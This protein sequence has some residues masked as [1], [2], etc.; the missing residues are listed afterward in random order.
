MFH[1]RTVSATLLVLLVSVPSPAFCWGPGAPWAS[2]LETNKQ[3]S[4]IRSGCTCFNPWVGKNQEFAGEKEFLCENNNWCFVSCNSKCSDKT[5]LPGF[6]NWR[7]KSTFACS[8]PDLEAN[9]ASTQAT[10]AYTPVSAVAT[11]VSTPATSEPTSVATSESKPGSPQNQSFRIITSKS[12]ESKPASSIATPESTPVISAESTPTTSES[13]PVSSATTAYTPVSSVAYSESTPAVSASNP[14]TSEATSASSVATSESKVPFFLSNPGSSEPTPASSVANSESK[15]ITSVATSESKPI[16]SVAPSESTPVTS[17][18]TPASSVA[19]FE[20]TKYLDYSDDYSLSN[21]HEEFPDISDSDLQFEIT[22]PEQLRL[23]VNVY[24]DLYWAKFHITKEYALQAAKQTMRQASKLLQH[25]SIKTK[26]ELVYE[27]TMFFS[28]E[29]IEYYDIDG[30]MLSEL[31]SPFRVGDDFHVAHVYLTADANLDPKYYGK[32]KLGSMCTKDEKAARLITYWLTSPARTGLT[33]A[34]ELG[35]LLGIK[36]DHTHDNLRDKCTD[37]EDSKTSKR[38]VM[39][40]GNDR[41]GWSHCSNKDFSSYFETVVAHS[42]KFCLETVQL[43]GC[44][45]SNCPHDKWFYHGVKHI[46]CSST[47]DYDRSWCPTE[48]G[49]GQDTSEYILGSDRW[50]HCTCGES[51]QANDEFQP[52]PSQSPS[53]I[54]TGCPADDLELTGEDIVPY[55]HAPITNSWE[56]CSSLCR[57]FPSCKYWSW[58]KKGEDKQEYEESGKQGACHVKTKISER[59]LYRKRGI[60]GSRVCVL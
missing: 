42:D 18:P 21:F 29:H 51:N 6:I 58:L 5:I 49:V 15:P 19:T 27:N 37:S 52:Q 48:A 47:D 31:R 44:I 11:S 10:T 40:Y 16:S 2:Y 38:F 33:V 25:P 53:T 28:K 59:G 7:C 57:V 35:H 26:I 34:H 46:G 8:E 54:V 23:H 22:Q 24:L 3:T 55:E 4:S 14:A 41:N 9:P 50:T 13:T 56:E 20:P 12:S 17:A 60:S 36:H 43:N 1:W 39:N 45:S 32:S 30:K